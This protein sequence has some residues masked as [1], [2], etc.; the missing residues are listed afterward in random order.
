[1]NDD[2]INTGE[3]SKLSCK[4]TDLIGTMNELRKT[5]EKA[6]KLRYTEIDVEKERAANKLAPDELFIPQHI[7]DSNIRK[8]QSSY[9]QY[10]T[11]SNRAVV[12]ADLDQPGADV[13]LIERDFTSRVRFDGWQ[14][15]EF[16]NIDGMQQNGY[17]VVEVV[18]DL[19]KSGHLGCEF[20]SYGDFGIPKDSKSIQEAELVVRHYYFT[21]ARLL[22][23]AADPKFE[24]NPTQVKKVTDTDPGSTNVDSASKASLY[25]IQKV[26]F[27]L[28]GVVNVAW[29]CDSITDDWLRAPRPLFVGRREVMTNPD[30]T[31]QVDV[32]TG[33]PVSTDAF[34]K[35]YPYFLAPYLISEDDTISNLKG[36]A[37]LDQQCQEAVT[38]LMSSFCTAHRRAAGL[39]FSKEQSSPDDD[40]LMK[41]NVFFETGALINA[42]VQQFQLQAP[43]SD[44]L[45]GIQSLVT[46]N[47]SEMSQVNWA[48]QNRKD[49]RKTATEVS[50]SMQTQQ[51]LSTVQVVLYSNSLRNRYS[52]MY[53]IISSRVQTGVLVVPQ[54]IAP[55]YARRYDIKPSGDV[56]VIERQQVIAAMKEAW[57]VMQNTPAAMAFLSDLLSKMFPDLAPKYMQ[58]IMQAQ[59]MQAQQQQQIQQAI[60]AGIVQLAQ[61]P[62][63]FSDEGKMI[64]LPKVQQAASAIQQAA[65]QPNQ[66]VAA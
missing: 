40:I 24:F 3:Y 25:K 44:L 56:D 11:Q 45:S 10:I 8:E 31:P 28:A 48:A 30:G 42:K 2:Y 15:P 64:A 46:S 39:Y 19:A 36:R 22:A 20:V 59:Q 34:E 13:Q 54:N 18:F 9:V 6:R 60:G 57:Q 61:S 53:S 37:Y 14:L 41:K 26:M 47:L 52:Y 5:N 66:G 32:M 58:I 16:A 4:I 29:C 12:M 35:N 50:A 1:M 62:Q 17:G 27:R 7:I 21:K 23:M 33:K 51:A 43:G 49:S 55:M 65:Q 38:S 63:M